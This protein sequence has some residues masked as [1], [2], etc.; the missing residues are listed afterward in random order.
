M[1]R[2]QFLSLSM[3]IFSPYV[4]VNAR[5]S[6]NSF[7]VLLNTLDS[8]FKYLNSK[9][10]YTISDWQN[11]LPLNSKIDILSEHILGQIMQDY[12]ENKV[13]LVD[14]FILSKTEI[15][16]YLAKERNA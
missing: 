3:L 7:G 15:M 8:P 12:R 13:D 9:S 6:Q 2:R 16:L 10:E 1:N 11:Q 4:K 14:G 5:D